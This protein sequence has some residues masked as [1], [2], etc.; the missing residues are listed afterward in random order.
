MEI[1]LKKKRKAPLNQRVTIS[2][3][4]ETQSNLER[5]KKDKQIDVNEMTRMFWD[6]LIQDADQMSA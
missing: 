2:T 1:Q 4:H 3:T 5:L 6:K